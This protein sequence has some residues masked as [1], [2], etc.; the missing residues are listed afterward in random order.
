MSG[1]F[2]LRKIYYTY[3]PYWKFKEI[4]SLITDFSIV[5]V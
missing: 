2:K 1:I 4:Y 5:V 3:V